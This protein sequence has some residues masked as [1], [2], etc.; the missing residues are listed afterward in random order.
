[1]KSKAKVVRLCL[2]TLFASTFGA[3]AIG[4]EKAITLKKSNKY[5]FE[6]LTPSA[7]VNHIEHNCGTEHNGQNWKKLQ[8]EF[9]HQIKQLKIE[10]SNTQK[11]NISQAL[12]SSL[13]EESIAVEG[14]YYI[15]LVI[16]VYGDA[17]NCNDD[18]ATCLTDN[19]INDAIRKLNDDFL[20]LSID[21]PEISPEF[22][23]IRE[24][25]N[26]EFV[27]AKK[28][29]DG[30]ATNGIVRHY[31]EEAGYGNGDAETAAKISADAWDNFKYM[32]VYLMNDLHDDGRGN[33]SG[34][35]WYPELAMSNAGIA[36]VV[37]NGNYTG[38]NTNE[39]FRSVLTHEFGHW[40]NLIHTFEDNQ[41]T[42]TN[43]AFCK[44]TGD[45]N[46]DTPQMS[47]PQQMQHNAKNCLGQPTNTENF[48][49]YTDNYAMFTQDQVA[50]MTAA[51]HG[52][53]RSTLWANDNLIATGLAAYVS[54]SNH[55]WDGISGVDIEPEGT[56]LATFDNISA[57]L[58]G[59][60]TVAVNIPTD[61]TNILFYLNGYTQDPDLYV[62]SGVV[63]TPPDNNSSNWIA[64]LIS[65]NAP[66]D[67]E[68]VS[69]D[70]P[71]TTKP[72][73]ASIHGFTAFDNAK[74][75]IIQGVDPFLEAGESRYTLFKID[76][77]WA[78]STDAMWTDR[79]GKSHNFTFTVPE[80]A[81]KVVIVVPGGY[82][83][84]KMADGS[85]N[86]NGDLDL[87]VSRNKE[88]SLETY[89]CRPF[90]WKVL[91]E[92][93]EFDGGGTFNVLIDPFQTYTKATL[94]VYYETANTGNQLPFANTNGSS[95]KEA[96]NHVI[97]FSGAHSNDPDGEII[98]YLWDFGDGAQSTEINSSHSYSSV[99]T[100]DVT[101]T[102]TDN[103][104]EST[105]ASSQAIITENSPNDAELCSDCTR[106]YLYDEINLSSSE[107][108]T[109]R[110][111]EFEVPDAASLV[112]FEVVNRYNGDPDMHISQN[113]E[114]SLES[115]DCR[116][117]SA[118]RETELCQFNEG[119]VFN[120]MLDPFHAY[121]S[122]RLRAYYDIRDDA[123]H[124][125]PNR[126]PVANAG[127][128]YE[129]RPNLTVNFNG[130]LSSDEDGSIT[131]Y[132]WDFGNG[133]TMVGSTVEHTYTAVGSYSVTLTVTDNKGAT[134]SQTTTVVI[135]PIGDFDGDGDVDVDDIRALTLAIRNN[136]QLDESFDINNDGVID[137]LDTI[138]LRSLCS[139]D[140][141]SNIKPP[142]QAPIAI[143]TSFVN[144]TQTNVS[145]QFNSDGSYDQYGQ[146]VSYE[147]NFGDG[148]NSELANPT[149]QYAEPGMYDVVLTVTDN[150]QMTAT[151]SIQINVSHPPLIDACSINNDENTS[152]LKPSEPRCVTSKKVF[153]FG[154]LN[155]DH[156]SVA[157]TLKYAPT[158]S[159]IY[160]KDGGWPQISTNDYSAASSLQGD[161]QCIFYDIP[162]NADYWGYI[163]VSGAPVG[164]TIVVDYD[165]AGCRPL[166]VEQ[167][168]E[169]PI[170][171][172]TTSNGTPNTDIQF[173]S[174]NSSDS[175][176]QIISYLWDFGDGTG[177]NLAV[178]I[179]Q[180]SALGQYDITLTITDNDGLTATASTQVIIELSALTDAC[181][182]PN[183]DRSTTDLVPGVA[184][185]IGSRGTYAF[186]NLKNHTS[187]AIT[188][189]NAAAQSQIYF[190]DG[191]RPSIYNDKYDVI[192][193]TQG[194]QQCIVYEIPND[195][196]YWGYVDIS[197]TSEGATI[198]M[199]YDV[200]TCRTPS[201]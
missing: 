125:G 116:P 194:T 36:R 121:D 28:D 152:D 181:V 167:P 30:N 47:L 90:S 159:L 74:L 179:H 175:D 188:M 151:S 149:H 190:M 99:G 157:I 80:D 58:D 147:W 156:N 44:T 139:Y 46:C 41:C 163:E 133:L 16:H 145:I 20:G 199:D 197:N 62:S 4:S 54:N 192:S 184:R 113:K 174:A 150:D 138:A 11:S 2:L 33:N 124:S 42:I 127:G 195:A 34:I 100:Y 7:D 76:N 108:E 27:L 6:S 182:D 191:G 158:D 169:A 148:N 111:F 78:N 170:A 21:S 173:S 187:V 136:E 193:T 176:G 59:I 88:V 13:I 177:S 117:F 35:A 164:A 29:P 131:D 3:Q 84:P 83:G 115:F 168:L 178:P 22:L 137:S 50:R 171:V 123:D 183:A 14:R 56:V 106:F 53:S 37:Y 8:R 81:K 61:A 172:I 143:A 102:V 92:Y 189:I 72:Y 96:V 45:K 31:R 141:C 87:H 9:L 126:L 161:Q 135:N 201:P 77:L 105:V 128:S 64:D 162:S 38:V 200:T 70:I 180:Y 40:L 132:L 134:N 73:Y 79:K 18:S 5:I 55:P 57:P 71:D 82:L 97:E 119:G 98:S 107:G 49:H 93:C 198:V 101:L 110:T 186:G 94:H 120:V 69:I 89:D 39:N 155:R 196:D 52:P 48:M 129:G 112:T 10:K 26:I 65:F 103:N 104:G 165:V 130:Q 51:L 91:A 122:V 67:I 160:F 15:P 166:N 24:N 75:Q 63:P 153:T 19:K 142:P 32:N 114:V 12:T 154:A 25:L 185:C 1:M 60:E 68:S 43:E 146:I 85:V 109:P 17:Y 118:P 86:Q 66:G 144:D 140:R 95:Y 23:A